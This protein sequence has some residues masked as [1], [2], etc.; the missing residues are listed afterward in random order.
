MTSTFKAPSSTLWTSSDVERAT[1]GTAGSVW[2]AHGVSIDPAT[3]A[4]GDLFVAIDA[5]DVTAAFANGAVAAIVDRMVMGVDP[6]RLIFVSDARQALADLGQAA[7][8]RTGAKI[9]SATGGSALLAQALGISAQTHEDDAMA[10]LA[11]ARMHAGSDYAVF[12]CAAQLRPHIAIVTADSDVF[13]GMDPNGVVILDRDQPSYDRFTSEAR[14]AGLKKIFSFGH[15]H[16]AD[17]RVIDVLEARNGV[18]VI[19]DLLG[20]EI[21]FRAAGLDKVGEALAALLAVRLMDGN[22]EKAVRAIELAGPVSSAGRR[23]YL[24]MGDPAN[25]VTLIDE[26]HTAAAPQAAFKVMALIDPGRGGRRIA[27][28][29][30]LLQG[31]SADLAL[32]LKTANVDL[33][34]TCGPMMKKLYDTLPRERQGQHHDSSLELAAIVPDVLV[35]GD[36][37]MVKGSADSKMNVVVEA[38]RAMPGKRQAVNQ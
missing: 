16:D 5:A 13:S 26:T 30:N 35:P 33:V 27:I 17:A 15:R 24:D 19:A 20:E 7:R 2:H 9:L 31:C 3:L 1:G 4:A 18:R 22:L 14:S 37:V 6:S 29:G 11:L 10:D 23:S 38:L 8:A 21:S 12:D 28:L 32:P 25:P 36:V 34:Y